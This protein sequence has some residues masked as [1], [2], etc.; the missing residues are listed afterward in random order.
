M[1]YKTILIAFLA[2]NAIFWSLFPH[3]IH[4][5]LVS[6]FM[7]DCPSHNIHLTIGILSFIIAFIVAQYDHLKHLM[8]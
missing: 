2:I 4:C 6:N 1:Y 3:N 7:I 8:M 5:K